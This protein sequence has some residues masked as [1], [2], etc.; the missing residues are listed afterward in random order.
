[1]RELILNRTKVTKESEITADVWTRRLH[2][3]YC[4][5]R[6][7]Q[8]ARVRTNCYHIYPPHSAFDSYKQSGAGRKNQLIIFN[9]YQKNKNMLFS[10]CLNSMGF[11]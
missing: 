7:I 6:S 1:M 4:F 11:F 3:V 2:K 9:N 5:G 10:C 8:S